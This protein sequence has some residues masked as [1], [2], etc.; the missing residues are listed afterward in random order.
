VL[1]ELRLKGEFM[2]KWCRGGYLAAIGLALQGVLV[3]HTNMGIS[4]HRNFYFVIGIVGC[5]LMMIGVRR[6]EDREKQSQFL[7]RE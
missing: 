7:D 3:I 1:S 2:E 5:A 6:E 4:G